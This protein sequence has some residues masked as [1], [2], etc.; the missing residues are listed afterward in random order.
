MQGVEVG[1]WLGA[2]ASGGV[3][4]GTV[5]VGGESGGVVGDAPVGSGVVAS[6]PVPAAVVWPQEDGVVTDADSLGV[7]VAGWVSAAGGVV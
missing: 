7:S 4:V 5:C 6:A 3:L 2:E 1:L